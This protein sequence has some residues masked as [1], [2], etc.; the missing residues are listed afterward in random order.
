MKIKY[1]KSL[2]LNFLKM[3]TF[4]YLMNYLEKFQNYL[5]KL[6][7]IEYLLEG[8]ALQKT[9]IISFQESNF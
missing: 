1:F 3:K 7:I 9:L 5:K 4:T 8:K 2:I 6:K